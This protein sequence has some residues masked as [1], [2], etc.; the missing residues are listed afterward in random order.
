MLSEYLFTD[1]LGISSQY[2]YIINN[3]TLF[4]NEI[5]HNNKETLGWSTRY[6]CIKP[7]Y[8]AKCNTEQQMKK[9]TLLA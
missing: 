4:N 5:E 9:L 1:S 6:V 7:P 3:S 8:I 2:L